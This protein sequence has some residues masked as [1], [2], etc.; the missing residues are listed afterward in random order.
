VATAGDLNPPPVHITEKHGLTEVQIHCDLDL[1]DAQLA[2]INANLD[3]AGLSPIRDRRRELR[4]A[5]LGEEGGFWDFRI[6]LYTLSGRAEG[7]RPLHISMIGSKASRTEP[8]PYRRSR[9]TV[10]RI[11]ALVNA[12]SQENLKAEFDCNLTWHSSPDSSLLPS[13]L[14]VNA[15]FPEESVIQEITGVIGGNPDGNVRF[16]VDRVAHDPLMFHVWL[17]SKH[18]LSL[19]P[20]VMVEAVTKGVS[21]MKDINVWDK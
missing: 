20:Q 17:G 11:R 18:E 7:P 15:S 8:T 16:V 12:L 21:M 2:R 14:P 19:S 6:E 4:W 13:V 10:E 5:T 1:S 9:R 3:S